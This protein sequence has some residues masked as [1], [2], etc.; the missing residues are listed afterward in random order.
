MAALVF[1]L[2][3]NTF[4]LTA[5]YTETTKPEWNLAAS[6]IKQNSD[7]DPLVLLDRGGLTVSSLLEYYSDPGLRYVKLTKWPR[8]QPLWKI[9][10]GKLFSITDEE[11]HFWLVLSMNR[12]TDDYYKDLLRSRYSLIRQ[13][14]FKD[15]KVYEFKSS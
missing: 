6:F 14:E 2:V 5:Y 9:D 15:I 4:A 11:D 10:Q 13:Q 7:T 8:G 1:L 12:G 3:T